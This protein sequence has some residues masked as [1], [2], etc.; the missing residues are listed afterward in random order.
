MYQ[1]GS[2]LTPGKTNSFVCKI[3]ILDVQ[4]PSVQKDSIRSCMGGGE[5]LQC[6]KGFESL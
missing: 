5:I 6:F 4:D 3:L 2:G 1:Y